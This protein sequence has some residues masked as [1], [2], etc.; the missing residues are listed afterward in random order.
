MIPWHCLNHRLELGVD[1]A[2]KSCTALNHF[3]IFIEK[4]YCVH[5]CSPK[6][7]YALQKCAA[8]VNAELLKIGKIL[9]TRWVASSFRTV[10]AVWVSYSALFAHF[11]EASNDKS[12]DGK[13][14]ATFSGLA[15]KLQT[16]SFLLNL[17]LMVDAL[18]ELSDLSESLQAQSITLPR[19][20]ITIKRQIEIFRARKETGW[21]Q[22][23]GGL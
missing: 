10:K 19:A 14:K 8:N 12:L 9:G 11:G 5:S 13:E 20:T 21:R 22:I 17:A 4:L 23:Q 16:K 6:N 2:V 15:R 1:D 3:K 7:R 18:Q